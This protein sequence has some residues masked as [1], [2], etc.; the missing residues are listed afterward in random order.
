MVKGAGN[1]TLDLSGLDA[2]VYIISVKAGDL[3]FLNKVE[4][5][6]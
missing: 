2:G 6:R 1:K 5:R 3:N 4:M